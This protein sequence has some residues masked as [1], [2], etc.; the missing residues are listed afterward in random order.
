[1]SGTEHAGERLA[2]VEEAVAEAATANASEIRKAM[3]WPLARI[4]PRIARTPMTTDVIR[5]TLT[6]F[7]GDALP[8]LMMEL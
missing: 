1:M 6:S 8:S 7:S 5:A 3:F 4:P 2:L